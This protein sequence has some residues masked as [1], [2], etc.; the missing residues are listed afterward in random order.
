MRRACR[1]SRV[2]QAHVNQ[3]LR[4]QDSTH[5]SPELWSTFSSTAKAVDLTV[6]S[7]IRRNSI[8]CRMR[9]SWVAGTGTAGCQ[10]GISGWRRRGILLQQCPTEQGLR[11][12]IH[13]TPVE[14][15]RPPGAR[16]AAGVRSSTGC[17]FAHSQDPQQDAAHLASKAFYMTKWRHASEWTQRSRR[18]HASNS[19][20]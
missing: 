18:G 17:I 4:W 15:T 8:M 11:P 12:A 10:R 9:S 3:E 20:D 7:L 2:M 1:T 5:D 13:E 19:T 16:V 14:P 6:C